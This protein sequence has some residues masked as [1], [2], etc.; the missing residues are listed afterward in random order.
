MKF[1]VWIVDSGKFI[2]FVG[3]PMGVSNADLLAHNLNVFFAGA[4][5]KFTAKTFAVG[6]VN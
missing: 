6:E 3:R 1:Q 2:Q 4:K 5:L